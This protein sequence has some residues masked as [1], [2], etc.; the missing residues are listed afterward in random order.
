MN[1]QN[2]LPPGQWEIDQF[3]GFGLSKYATRFRTEFDP[4]ELA[5]SG[6]VQN[7]VTVRTDDLKA[8]PRVQQESDF[9]C[10]TTW[11][12][13]GLLWSGFRFSDFYET[14]IKPKAQPSEQTEV[15]IFRSQD[16][17]GAS[18]PLTDLLSPDVLLADTLDGVPLTAEHG[19]P[20]RLVAPAHY[21]YKNAKHLKSIEFCHDESRFRPSAFRF[22]IHPRA[23]VALEERGRWVPSWLLR[24]LYR[25]LVKPTIREFERAMQQL[26][27]SGEK[28]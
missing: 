20:L 1:T 4:L 18:L 27:T 8:L 24:I 2:K 15:V 14:I 26:P 12:K 21:G 3:P 25:P 17:F 16:G 28:K 7:S 13:K 19:A 9:H 5:V 23:R 10:V 6:D 11:T 22:I